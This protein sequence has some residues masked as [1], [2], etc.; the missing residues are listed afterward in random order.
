MSEAR[1][2][3]PSELDALL[4]FIAER[5]ADPATGTCYLGTERASIRLELEEL[6]DAWPGSALVVTDPA[7]R[8]VGASVT[9][10]DPE[11]GR[12]WIHGP[13]VAD[14]RWD[15]LAPP[16]L[17]AAI[18]LCPPEV[19]AHE[20]SGD[21]SNRRMA[22]LA[23]ELGWTASVPNHVFV[24]NADTASTWPDD[25]P[26][27][28]APRPDDFAAID[29]LHAAEFPN[30]YLATRPMINE[31]IA[32]DRITLV[33]EAAGAVLGYAAGRV[34]PDGT[35]Y[36]DFIAVVPQARR[37]GAG[38]GLLV[39]VSRRIIESAPAGDVNLTVQ[40]HRAPAIAL[41][42]RLGFVRET[43]IVGYSSPRLAPQTPKVPGT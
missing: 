16:L 34:Q 6:G 37:S 43:I 1:R 42:Q 23:A 32:G 5:Q 9:E 20:F 13:W 14:D 15:D 11:L 26:R 24:A 27:V 35:G 19:Q 33:S 28:R 12:S 39:T 29:P 22:D 18:A 3:E 40:E 21:V 8:I 10:A 31:G 41:Y 36:L 30:T 38:L 25:D 4:D 7:G 17:E 2:V